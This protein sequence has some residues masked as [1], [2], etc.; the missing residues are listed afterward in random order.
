MSELK[1]KAIKGVRWTTLSAGTIAVGGIIQIYILT[2]LLDQGDFGSMAIVNIALGFAVH[3]VDMGFG[4]AIIQNQDTTQK[5]LSSLYWLNLG[6]SSLVG[7]AVFLGAPAVADFYEMPELKWML[8]M[9]APAFLLNGLSMQFQALLQK[10]LRFQTLA[11][12]EIIAFLSGFTIAVIMALNDYGPYALVGG[13]LG[14]I[15][16]SSSGLLI[17]GMRIHRPGFYFSK[18]AI[19]PYWNFGMYQV[20]ERIIGYTALNLDSLLIGKLLGQQTLGVYDVVKRIL[21]QP[22]FIITPIVTKVTYPIL[23][24]VQNEADRF[25]NIALRTVNMVSLINV[26]IYISCSLG[27]FLLVPILFDPRWSS[28]TL[29]FQWLALV[30]MF[31]TIFSPLGWA[32]LAQKKANIS[33]IMNIILFIGM[34]VSIWIGSNYGLQGVLT[35][36]LTFS[37]LLIIPFY[38]L[39][40]K[41]IVR[42]NWVE[43]LKHFVPEILVSV[44][45][46]GV[47]F[48]LVGLLGLKGLLAAVFFIG[49]GSIIYGSLILLYRRHLIIEIRQMLSK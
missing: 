29:P 37:A 16:I 2:R 22:W 13:A 8:R 21:I 38:I 25:R 43:F 5:Q 42:A 28:G 27:A 17:F 30:F 20:M 45:G 14:K 33:F 47:S 48:L 32:A 36:M 35:G 4:N 10:N 34:A 49:V 46:F 24:L 26:P 44:T 18:S 23:S 6:M 15:I 11:L 40:V 3:L 31:R 12:T 1:T 19:A 9:V 39:M 7:L 41:P